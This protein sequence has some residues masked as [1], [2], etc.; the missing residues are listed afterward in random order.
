MRN[1]VVRCFDQD[2]LMAVKDQLRRDPWLAHSMNH[3]TEYPHSTKAQFRLCHQSAA[4]K[5]PFDWHWLQPRWTQQVLNAAQ[6][7]RGQSLMQSNGVTNPGCSRRSQPQV[8]V[9]E[10]K[11]L[12]ATL[13]LEFVCRKHKNFASLAFSACR[14][15]GKTFN[16][17]G[18]QCYW[19][20]S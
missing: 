4:A 7:A 2:G 3:D 18:I 5:D 17:P 10:G 11:F 14:F 9:H 8:Q 20:G 6:Q 15:P 16:R 19:G 12:L 13:K 1:V